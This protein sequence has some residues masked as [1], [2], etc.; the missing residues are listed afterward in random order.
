MSGSDVITMCVV[1]SSTTRDIVIPA[2]TQLHHCSEGRGGAGY[3][4]ASVAIGPDFTG[5]LVLQCHPDLTKSGFIEYRG[6]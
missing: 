3:V 4:E 6:A 1:P 5:Y 2:G